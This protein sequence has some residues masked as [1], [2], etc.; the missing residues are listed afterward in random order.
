[1]VKIWADFFGWI[2]LRF[3]SV[4]ESLSF[5][6]LFL[7]SNT[8]LNHVVSDSEREGSQTIRGKKFKWGSGRAHGHEKNEI[9]KMCYIAIWCIT[10]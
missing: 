10:L 7:L 9:L 3:G 4:L 2:M 5:G 6:W 1:M 8:R